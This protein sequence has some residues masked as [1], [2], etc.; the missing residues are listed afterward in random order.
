MD[1]Y[2]IGTRL[3]EDAKKYIKSLSAQT[4][5]IYTNFE[6]RKRI[7]PHMTFIRPFTTH[8]E[9]GVIETFNHVL[10]KFDEPIIYQISGLDTFDEPERVLYASVD[11][12]P[13]I[14]SMLLGLEGELESKTNYLS[15][16]ASSI[17]DKHDINLHFAI[18]R[19]IPKDTFRE[20]KSFLNS[21]TFS[22]IEH[23]LYRVY[24]LKNNLILKEY[25]FALK[26][27]LDW[28]DAIDPLVF[29]EKTIPEFRK[30]SGWN[31]FRIN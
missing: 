10:S 13:K 3:R 17:G 26:R 25:D 15:K 1:K 16:K 5:K 2:E 6:D 31:K 23:P 11:E 14:N 4:S 8:D 22:P 24:L 27:S 12:N 20:I 19:N 9:R 18:A 29:D 21:R 7:V 30:F 28:W